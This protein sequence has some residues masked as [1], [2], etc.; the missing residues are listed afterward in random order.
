M[1]TLL[2]IL[3]PVLLFGQTYSTPIDSLVKY[4]WTYQIVANSE[5]EVQ[6]RDTVLGSSEWLYKKVNGKYIRHKELTKKARI[7]ELY[8][9]DQGKKRIL[10]KKVFRE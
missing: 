6:A 1:K 4:D 2:A 9:W 8:V 5:I 10:I 3:F 7:I